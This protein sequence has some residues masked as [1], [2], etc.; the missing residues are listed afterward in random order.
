M[1]SHETTA[2]RRNGS[3]PA[4][5]ITPVFLLSVPRAGST[6]VQ[7]VL[8]AHDGVATAAE[9]WLLLPA[10][11]PLRK[12]MPLAP[13][14]YQTM[15]GAVREFVAELPDGTHSYREALRAFAERLYAEAAPP[16][17]RFFL[18]KS[19]AYHLVADDVIRTFPNARFVFLWRSPLS[20]LASTVETF[21]DGRWRPG[22]HRGD[23]FNGVT[24]LV[25][26]Y[27]QAGDRAHSVRY[28]DLLTRGDEPWQALASYVGVDFDPAALRRFADVELAGSMGDPTGRLRYAALDRKPLEKWRETISNPLRREWAIRYLRWL[29]RRRLAVMGYDLDAMIEELEAVQVRRSGLRRDAVDVVSALGRDV[30]RGRTPGIA[31]ASRALLAPHAAGR[32]GGAR[33]RLGSRS[34]GS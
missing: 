27:E 1:G 2:Q 33:G 9:P 10:L 31:S 16:G 5:A 21:C 11:L 25:H 17:A 32:R 29:G 28:E 12:P 3:R 4:A 18:D 34:R 24:N 6:L 13:G 14:W 22:S 7:R 15:A 8:G 23:L 30:A 19:P 26:A 20:V